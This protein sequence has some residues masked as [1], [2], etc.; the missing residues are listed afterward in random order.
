MK[1]AL[2]ILLEESV[3]ARV[4]NFTLSSEVEDLRSE[5]DD[6]Q[7]QQDEA[8]HEIS[9]YNLEVNFLLRIRCNLVNFL[10]FYYRMCK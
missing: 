8:L 9:N 10:K 3:A 1:V 6:L 7:R 5:L 4:E 2:K